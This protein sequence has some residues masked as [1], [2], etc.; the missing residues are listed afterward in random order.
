MT[1]MKLSEFTG[2]GGEATSLKH[3]DNAAFFTITNVV[4]SAYD[5]TP[6]V[7]LT[8]HEAFKVDGKDYHEFYTTRKA[9][10]DTLTKE[11]I[12]SGLKNGGTLRVKVATSMSKTNNKPY[13]ILEEA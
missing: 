13:F 2:S 12:R 11:N 10:V 1:E 8:T 9:I 4:D 7:R 3:L 5:D 6:G